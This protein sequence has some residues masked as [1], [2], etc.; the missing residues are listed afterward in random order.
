MRLLFLVLLLTGCT[1]NHAELKA[2][3]AQLDRRLA[4]SMAL[5]QN[6]IKHRQEIESLE[7]KL[8]LALELD[9][10][11]REAIEAIAL[12]P[13]A[14]AGPAPEPPLPPESMFEW[15]EGAR[16]R[17]RITESQ[18][19]LAE[20]DKVL[21]EVGGLGAKRQLLERKLAAISKLREQ[22]EPAP[23]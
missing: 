6:L 9:P 4:A 18:R 5:A 8:Q 2:R 16:L 12:E 1:K 13:A 20:L 23:R 21:G 3:E 7:T 11:A 17:L 10:S 19:R 22:R 15:A 14:P